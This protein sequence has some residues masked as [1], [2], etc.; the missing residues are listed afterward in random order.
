MREWYDRYH[1]QGF[2]VIGVHSPEFDY[3][4]DVNNVQ[5][6][7]TELGVTWPVAIDND[8]ATWRA[9]GNN[10]W[11]AMYIIDKQG[12]IRYYKIGEGGYARTE[13]IIQALL[14]EPV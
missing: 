13:A 6:A 9:Y 12:N 3:E 5:N 10:Y 7:C 1:D 14:A 4:K 8:F 2:E 11:P